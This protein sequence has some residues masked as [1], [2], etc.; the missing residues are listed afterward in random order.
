[1]KK[2]FYLPTLLIAGSTVLF[3]CEKTDLVPENPGIEPKKAD[4]CL[5]TSFRFGSSASQYILQRQYDAAGNLKQITAGVYQGGAIT[6][7]ITLDA[8]WAAGSLALI[9][10]G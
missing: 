6:R 7:T 9:K 3:S 10:A 8:H 4:N 5:L 1:M 2:S